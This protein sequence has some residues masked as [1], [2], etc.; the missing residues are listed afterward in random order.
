M[1][2]ICVL[3]YYIPLELVSN[4]GPAGSIAMIPVN[5]ALSFI[6]LLHLSPF[7]LILM[8]HMI[9]TVIIIM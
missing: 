8:V 4:I 3:V 1:C 2:I 7:I 6:G 5:V 9:I